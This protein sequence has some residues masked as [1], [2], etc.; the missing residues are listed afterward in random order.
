M[1][2]DGGGLLAHNGKIAVYSQYFQ[3]VFW[4]FVSEAASSIVSLWKSQLQKALHYFRRRSL[5][6]TIHPKP[7]APIATISSSL[8]SG[9]ERTRLMGITRGDSR[10]LMSRG[11]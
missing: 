2:I 4:G 10:E 6:K 8:S 3:R 1:P 7:F 11:S 9:S 5:V